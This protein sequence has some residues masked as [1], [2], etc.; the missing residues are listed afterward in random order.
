MSNKTKVN[1]SAYRKRKEAGEKIVMITA[2]DA[3]GAAAAFAAGIDMLLVGDSMAMT[4]LGYRNTLPL[5][6]DE[7]IFH[8]QA[9]RRGAPDAFVIFDMPFMSYQV[10]MEEALR[11]AGRAIK[12]AG[13]DAVK[14]EGGAELN[15]L[16]SRLVDAGIPVMAHIGLL[17]Q[18]IQTS[19]TY[20][21][22]GRTP[23]AAAKLLDDARAVE[24]AGAFAVVLECM[25]ADLGGELSRAL[26]IPTIGIGSGVQCDGQI[27]VLNDVLGLFED[28]TPKHSRR[29]AELGRITREALQSYA[30]DVRNGSFPGPENSFQ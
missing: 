5:S 28:F 14:L 19:G 29:Y 17:P 6:M 12:E 16:I 27:Q 13:A 11:N 8:T 10:S 22:T 24:A 15:P 9:V 1:V 21:V 3:P 4:V 7:A 20:R 30:N 2:Y 26:A 25:P 23:E 18:R